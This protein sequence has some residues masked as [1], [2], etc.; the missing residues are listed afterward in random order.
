M[1]QPLKRFPALQPISR[2]HHKVLQ[3]CFK[4]RQGI[5]KKVEADRILKYVQYFW[6]DFY[7]KHTQFQI[8]SLHGCLTEEQFALLSEKE[9]ELV[10]LHDALKALESD[11]R[12]FEKALYEH[13]R[14]E[15]RGLFQDIQANY[16]N[17]QLEQLI[18]TEEGLDDWCELYEDQFWL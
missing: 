17:S 13:V 10:T 18:R 3:C 12:T 5:E 9:E 4:V 11:L 6:Q 2:Q 14:W 7:L 8:D 16:E 1:P 15:E